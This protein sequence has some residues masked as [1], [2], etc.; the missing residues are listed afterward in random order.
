LVIIK[1]MVK[2]TK[3][4]IVEES[5]ESEDS[6]ELVDESTSPVSEEKVKVKVKRAP[7]K[8][9]IFVR[10][11][12]SQFKDMPPRERM[13]AVGELWAREKAKK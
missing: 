2:R 12:I 3:T 5:T 11:N 1:A 9:N 7:S 10:E 8:Y 13:S 6:T 4:K